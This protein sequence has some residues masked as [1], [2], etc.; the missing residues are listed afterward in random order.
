MLIEFAAGQASAFRSA[1]V[2]LRAFKHDLP[3]GRRHN[4]LLLDNFKHLLSDQ[5]DEFDRKAKA[6]SGKN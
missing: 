5:A 6:L 2:D 3:R 1:A 4:Q